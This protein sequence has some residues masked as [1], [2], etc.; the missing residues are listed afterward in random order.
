M[1]GYVD[2]WMC[3]VG[4]KS[5][6]EVVGIYDFGNTKVQIGGCNYKGSHHPQRP[7]DAK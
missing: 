1:C 2:M 6:W 4:K 7:T 5:R 3:D